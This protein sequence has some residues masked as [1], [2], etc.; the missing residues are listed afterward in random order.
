MRRRLLTSLVLALM[1]STAIIPPSIAS[2]DNEFDWDLAGLIAVQH[3]GRVKPLSTFARDLV[4]QVHGHSSYKSQHPL[5]T[6]FHW[7]S[8]GEKWSEEKLFYLTK[9][10]LRSEME[11]PNDAGNYFRMSELQVNSGLMRLAREGAAADEKGDKPSFTQTKANELLGRMQALSTVFSHQSPRMVPQPG[12]DPQAE[13]MTLPALLSR[14]DE[15]T[16]IPEDGQKVDDPYRAMAIAFSGMYMSVRDNRPDMFNTSLDVFLENQALILAEQPTVLSKLHWEEV[17]LWLQPYTVAKWLLVVALF[18]LGLSLWRRLTV[19]EYA[20]LS[21]LVG[22]LVFYTG[23]LA[24]RAYISGRA[25][26][27]NMYESLLAIGWSLLIVAVVYE[28]IRRDRV[29]AMV[30]SALGI[31]IIGIAQY[32]SLDRGINPLVPALQSYWLNYHVIITLASYACFA[33]AMGVGHTVLV[34]GIRSK[35]AMTPSL[36]GL[37]K[38]NLKIVQVG[39]LLIITG[40]LLGAVWA[41]VSWGRFWGWDPKE[42]WALITW[43]VYIILLHGR[44]AGWLG[45]RGFAACSVGAFPIVIMTYYGVNFY[46]SGLHSY[47]AG[48]APGVPWQMFAYVAAEGGFLFWALSRLKGTLPTRPKSGQGAAQSVPSRVQTS[49]VA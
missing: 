36:A 19:V 20:G 30:G 16:L 39:S 29:M 15:G 23:G 3:G 2:P 28:L 41:N 9:G 43:F 6:Y 38:A 40:I 22:A 44:S 49:E 45:W 34:S 12:G 10:P 5:E 33:I 1:M 37:A 7:M 25:P 14:Y 31:F 13:W 24:L 8:D 11:L 26:W 42:T 18:A 21:A 17:Y 48:S 32:A 4:A 35:G 47:G 27:S 46:L